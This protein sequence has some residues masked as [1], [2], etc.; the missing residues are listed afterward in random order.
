MSTENVSPTFKLLLSCCRIKHSDWAIRMR[1]EALMA[2]VNFKTLLDLSERHRISPLAYLQLKNDERVQRDVLLVLK[3]RFLANRIQALAIKGREQWLAGELSAR[4]VNFIFLKGL[5]IA[6]KYYGDLAYRHVFDLDVLVEKSALKVVDEAVGG[7]G[8]VPETDLHQFNRVQNL[9]YTTVYHDLTYI[10]S[11]DKK[12]VIELHWRFRDVLSGF[13]LDVVRPLDPVEE[14]LYIC[15]HGTEHA[16]FRLK[17][18]C[19]VVQMIDV[20]DFD[21]QLVADRAT[22]LGCLTHLQLTW[23]LLNR[24]FEWTIPLPVLN[25]M[26]SSM[27]ECKFRHIMYCIQSHESIFGGNYMRLRHLIFTLSFRKRMAGIPL[28]LRYMSSPADWKLLPLPGF[29]FWIYFLLRPVF[30]VWRMLKG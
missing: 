8:F 27:H 21:W 26:P 19:D 13:N 11:S 20:G 2:G 16:W 15:T 28:L 1:E 9:F 6:E 23:R 10:H 25:G 22:E 24:L 14:L 18:L 3:E 5:Q 29:F 12:E 17:W 4:K 30:M 7:K